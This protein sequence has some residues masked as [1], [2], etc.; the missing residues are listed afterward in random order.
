MNVLIVELYFFDAYVKFSFC[1]LGVG[2][3]CDVMV[4]KILILVFFG[5]IESVYVCV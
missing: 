5:V 1:L 3:M 4:D 2:L